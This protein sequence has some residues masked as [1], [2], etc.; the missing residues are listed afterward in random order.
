MDSVSTGSLQSEPSASGSRLIQWSLVTELGF[1]AQEWLF[2]LCQT[3][4]KVWSCTQSHT[5]STLVCAL[6]PRSWL[7][8]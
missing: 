3:L 7:L 2:S 4:G 6:A 8:Y 5:R 1:D